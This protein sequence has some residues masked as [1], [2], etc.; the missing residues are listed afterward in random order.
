MDI[1]R[2]S[3][4]ILFWA[5]L[6]AIALGIVVGLIIVFLIYLKRRRTSINSLLNLDDLIGQTGIV[7]IPFDQSKSGKIRLQLEGQTLACVAYSDDS[8]RFTVGDPVIVVGRKGEKVWVIPAHEF[9]AR[10]EHPELS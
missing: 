1:P 2:I 10:P 6:A 9:H 4:D 7:E 5:A 3:Q 8:H